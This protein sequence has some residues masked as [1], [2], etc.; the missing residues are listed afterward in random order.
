MKSNKTTDRRGLEDL[1]SEHNI[2]I[3][4]TEERVRQLEQRAEAPFSFQPET[5]DAITESIA[6]RVADACRLVKPDL[7]GVDEI[8]RKAAEAGVCQALSKRPLRI[9]TE[10]THRWSESQENKISALMDKADKLVGLVSETKITPWKRW[11]RNGAAIACPVVIL[12][13]ILTIILYTDS[14]QYWGNRYY[15]VCNHPLQTNEKLL[16]HKQDAY[17]NVVYFF[18]NGRENKRRM[19][20]YIR[21]QEQRLKGK[22]L[23]HGKGE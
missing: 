4:E 8:I 22:E 23:E 15:Q 17:E 9:E 10:T 11:L 16:E 5:V 3:N 20:A 1:V 13:F 6:T 19:K 12:L 7:S 14:P 18:D 2:E 21:E